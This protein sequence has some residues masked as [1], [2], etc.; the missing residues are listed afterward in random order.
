METIMSSTVCAPTIVTGNLATFWEGFAREHWEQRPG[1]FRGLMTSPLITSAQAF[2]GVLRAATLSRA[3]QPAFVRFFVDNALVQSRL[4]RY[5]PTPEDTSF[6][7]YAK[8]L[9]PIIDH[10]RFGLTVNGFAHHDFE[11]FTRVRRFLRGLYEE[12]G[13]PAD[14]TDLDVFIGNYL[15]TPFGVHLDASSNFCVVFEGVKKFLVWPGPSLEERSELHHSVDFEEVRDEALVLEGRPGDVV[16]WPSSYWHIAE[17]SGELSAV[18]NIA[19]Y[20]DQDG[21]AARYVRDLEPQAPS[22]STPSATLSWDPLL[23]RK[24]EPLKDAIAAARA[25]NRSESDRDLLRAWLERTTAYNFHRTRPDARPMRELKPADT[26]RSEVDF[27]IVCVVDGEVLMLG[28]HG[29][30]IEVPFVEKVRAMIE[31]L[32]DGQ[33]HAVS[34][35]IASTIGPAKSGAHTFELGPVEVLS[36][37]DNLLAMRAIHQEGA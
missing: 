1:V 32:N 10:R 14:T 12:V 24:L 36:V 11:L 8:R 17:S 3:G 29:H 6:A 4:A 30:V 33:P 27:P 23:T 5:L 13:M 28:A 19:L 26:V 34:E 2:S 18:M 37:L 35:L 22:A 9:A 25:T 21:R 31:R 20:L 16:Y 15:H 7:D